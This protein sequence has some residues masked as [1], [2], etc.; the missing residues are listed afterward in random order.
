MLRVPVPVL[1]CQLAG[2]TT[3]TMKSSLLQ[4]HLVDIAV[5][6]HGNP[7]MDHPVERN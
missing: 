2:T 5:E 7:A 1:G 6:V 3:S 4:I